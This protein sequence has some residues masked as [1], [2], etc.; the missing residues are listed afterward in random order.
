MSTT[1]ET[2][3]LIETEA[4]EARIRLH[5]V[6]A[7]VAAVLIVNDLIIRVRFAEA[8]TL[9]AL[10]SMLGALIVAIPIL[11][12]AVEDL[13]KNHLRMTELVALAIIAA[14]AIQE[15]AIAGTIGFFVLVSEAVE[16]RTALGA[17]K[18]I[19]SLIRL[20]PQV[21]RIVT[22]DGEREIPVSELR[23]G[24]LIRIRPG[25]NVPADGIVRRGQS[26]LNQAS[27][28]GE[29]LPAD[30]TVG[31]ETF[32][33][34]VNL[35][36][37]LDVEVTQVGA[38]TTLGKVRELILK[39]QTTKSAMMKIVE[40]HAQW[41]TPTVFMVAGVILYFTRDME[42]AI[43]ALV[44]AC[45]GA[46]VLATPTAMVA[47]ISCAARLGILVKRAADL[48]F[49]GRLSVMIFD[50]TGTLTTGRL[51]VTRLSP[52]QGTE[53]EE[54]VKW[55]ASAER[56][57]NHPVARAL[58]RL[59]ED[60][61]VTLT[62][63]KEFEETIG[64]GVRAVVD[65]QEVRVGRLSWLEDEGVDLESAQL[66]SA[67]SEALS[68]IYVARGTQCLGWVGLED[69]PREEALEAT[70]ELRELG[71]ERL[72]I[73][74][75]D[76]L[77]VAEKVAGDLGCTEFEAD[78]LPETKLQVLERLRS[79]NHRIAVIG[80]GV[81][82][83]PALAASDLGIAMGAAGNDIAMNSASIAL[84]NDDLSRIPFLIRLS[85]RTRSVVNQ[86]LLFGVLFIV[87]GLTLS[88]FGWL[89]PVAAGI[90]YLISS[91]FVVFNSARIVRFG[92]ELTPHD[93]YE[94]GA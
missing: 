77:A 13:R 84:M 6:V 40:Q 47:A 79:E 46:I 90:L 62:E 19:E 82:D 41:Y 86:N 14:F 30:K 74:T 7:F 18:A 67:E 37:S 1:A 26:S 48:E 91:V 12:R 58:A 59:A 87:S 8:E 20:T 69:R 17:R 92:E 83:A 89:S 81:N 68:T 73:L 27:I 22:E 85:R 39:A 50:K 51:D 78:C 93:V 54:L 34:T 38:E 44:V 43:T 3:L 45:P 42:R 72:I 75:G 32:A 24:Q 56:D 55:A 35:T 2:A 16:R 76:R 11:L 15:Y 4:S 65:G 88:A 53:P 60:A 28:T 71:V 52:A 80:D 66:E 70:K 9:G 5:L 94:R 29:S 57:S 61:R 23:P 21:A 33:G 31:D 10:S 25:E 36:G 64:K 63:P 49:A